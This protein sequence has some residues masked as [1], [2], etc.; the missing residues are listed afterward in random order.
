MSMVWDKVSSTMG[1]MFSFPVLWANRM[2]IM[3]IAIRLPR[4]MLSFRVKERFILALFSL[5]KI[6]IFQKKGEIFLIFYATKES[7]E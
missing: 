7:K 4:M 6:H 5:A 2:M 3:P 1:R